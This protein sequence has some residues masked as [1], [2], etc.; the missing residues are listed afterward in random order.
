MTSHVTAQNDKKEAARKRV[1]M[2]AE[3]RKQH[4]EQAKQAQ[5]LLK[6][7]QAARKTLQNALQAG[8]CTVPQLAQQTGMAAH[9]VLWHVTAMKKY[10]LVVEAGMDEDEAYYLYA[11]P[12]EAQA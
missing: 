9:E 10:G 3:L 11:L 2:L 8:P 7:Q 5:A 4:G 6:E 12:K 1:Q